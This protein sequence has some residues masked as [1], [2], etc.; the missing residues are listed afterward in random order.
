MRSLRPSGY[1]AR[2]GSVVISGRRLTLPILL[3]L[4][5]P[6]D[7][8]GQVAHRPWIGLGGGAGLAAHDPEVQGGVGAAVYLNAG[9]VFGNVRVGAEMTVGLQGGNQYLLGYLTAM[10][11]VMVRAVQ[12]LYVKGGV[13]YATTGRDDSSA[14]SGPAWI[15]GGTINRGALVL[16]VS[17][18]T[19]M[20]ECGC[21]GN[22]N[23][24]PVLVLATIGFEF[25]SQL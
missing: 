5:F 11:V 19:Q 13:G 20:V 9:I 3:I 10:P 8:A 25:V 12:N 24:W 17:V 4:I 14:G 2:G 18:L 23:D 16:G 21:G 7:V 6:L 1:A 22:Q 15:V